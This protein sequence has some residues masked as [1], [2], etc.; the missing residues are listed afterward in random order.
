MPMGALTLGASY[1]ETANP[2]A[3]GTSN[4]NYDADLGAKT[5]TLSAKY[6]A[7][8][9]SLA[10]AL[11]RS[12]YALAVTGRATNLELGATYDLGVAKLGF[13]YDAKPAYAALVAPVIDKAALAFGVSVPMGQSAFGVN[14]AKRG[15][16]KI[17]EVGFQQ[18]LSARTNVNASF[19]THT[20]GGTST[21]ADNRAQY[22]VSLNH[23]F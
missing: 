9:L 6:N 7:G 21:A 2:A 5:I 3:A 15:V 17:V 23:A 16:A 12:N 13:G 19:G 14:F 11:K 4:G 8:P 22:R 18:N 10:A 1:S 20:I